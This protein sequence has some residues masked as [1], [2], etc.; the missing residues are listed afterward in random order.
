MSNDGGGS[1]KTNYMNLCI[2]DSIHI[3]SY[4]TI[5]IRLLKLFF[6][7]LHYPLH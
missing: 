3:K 6:L 2:N 5:K 7:F 1:P 4:E